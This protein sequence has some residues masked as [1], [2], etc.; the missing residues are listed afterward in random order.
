VID[1]NNMTVTDRRN[2]EAIATVDF[3]ECLSKDSSD[4]L[5]G[6][7]LAG[8]KFDDFFFPPKNEINFFNPM[9]QSNEQFL[10]FNILSLKNVEVNF[11]AA[12]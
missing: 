2:S 6:R 12:N 9:S 10:S 8:K 3:D 7:V 11:L 5:L 1:N 4:H